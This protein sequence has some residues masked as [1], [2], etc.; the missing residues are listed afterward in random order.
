MESDILA[1][2]HWLQISYR[3]IERGDFAILSA[4][5]PLPVLLDTFPVKGSKQR[6]GTCV[7]SVVGSLHKSI[8]ILYFY[9][10]HSEKLHRLCIFA[11]F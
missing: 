6:E 4:H 8:L 11:Y 5:F 1:S 10:L 7:E 2:L 3:S 9:F